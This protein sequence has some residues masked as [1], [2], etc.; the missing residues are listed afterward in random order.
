MRV[1]TIFAAVMVV[2]LIAG[3]TTSAMCEMTCLPK[4]QTAACC[5]HHAQQMVMHCQQHSETAS[6]V[7]AH[8]CE[9]PQDSAA[10]AACIVAA[11]SVISGV[12]IGTN[13]QRA[14]VFYAYSSSTPILKPLHPPLRI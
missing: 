10:V 3:M 7:N 6:F 2:L 8:T 12:I 9:H 13:L 4:A 14:P 5:P 11:P 1:R